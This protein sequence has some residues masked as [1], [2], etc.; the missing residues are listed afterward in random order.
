MDVPIPEETTLSN[1]D[2]VEINDAMDNRLIELLA[3]LSELRTLCKSKMNKLGL[4]DTQRVIDFFLSG[5]DVKSLVEQYQLFSN[6]RNSSTGQFSYGGALHCIHDFVRTDAFVRGVVHHVTKMR[7]QLKR[8]M[9]VLDAGCG[10]VGILGITAALTD[11]QVQVILLDINT[12][13]TIIAEKIVEK[14][15]LQDRVRVVCADAMTWQPKELQ[16]L[17]VSETMYVGF[18]QGEKLPNI[19]ANLSKFVQ[20]RGKIMPQYVTV[21]IGIEDPVTGTLIAPFTV[22]QRFEFAP[23]KTV[24]VS[25]VNAHSHFPSPVVLQEGRRFYRL[26]ASTVGLAPDIVI[27]P[28]SGAHI[29]DPLVIGEEYGDGTTRNG[30]IVK[31]PIGAFY[32]D[33]ESRLIGGD[34][35]PY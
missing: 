26:I 8:P 12:I 15:N 32:N 1:S 27:R 11:P 31:Y 18:T 9:R 20:P 30:F 2:G 7:G 16:D 5:I 22:G 4:N 25:G 19:M 13:S 33:D 6:D 24:D 28:E 29:T 21:E 35:T 17:L 14:F 3:I 10:P 34:I 23:S